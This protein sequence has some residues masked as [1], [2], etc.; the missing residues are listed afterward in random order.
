M[1]NEKMIIYGVKD[2]QTRTP[3]FYYISESQKS[4][5]VLC[6]LDYKKFQGE[7]E[8][9]AKNKVGSDKSKFS[10][11]ILGKLPMVS[12]ISWPNII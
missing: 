9:L 6:N 2:C 12:N 10:V 4:K 5:L 11:I 3:G 8:C 7:Y 1:I